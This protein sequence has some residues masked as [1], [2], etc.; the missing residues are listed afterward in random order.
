MTRGNRA[1]SKG[2]Q[3]KAEEDPNRATQP[4]EMKEAGAQH[5]GEDMGAVRTG[6]EAISK[7]IRELNTELKGDFKTLKEEIKR[8]VREELAE[9]K[10]DVNQKLTANMQ[11]MQEQKAKIDELET[12][13][14]ETETWSAEA[15]A[16]I[17]QTVRDLQKLEEKLNNLESRAR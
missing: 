4:E 8:D 1:K 10:Q 14:D 2:N 17:Q 6:L 15:K 3:D 12:R 13:V 11:V 5:G 16:A 7:Q 9:C